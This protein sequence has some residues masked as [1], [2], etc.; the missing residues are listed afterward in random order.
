MDLANFSETYNPKW[1]HQSETRHPPEKPIYSEK[2]VEFSRSNYRVPAMDRR[3]LR[4]YSQ[5]EGDDQLTDCRTES[6]TLP[7][8][9][10][11]GSASSRNQF[12][13]INP[14]KA[15]IQIDS[16]LEFPGKTKGKSVRFPAEPVVS[17]LRTSV[18]FLHFC[19]VMKPT[20]KRSVR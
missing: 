14:T 16:S 8:N 4:V 20:L 13:T 18:K 7:R 12:S 9:T 10:V 17:R 19:L 6:V 5:F 15:G 2:Y 1:T 3:R 11:E